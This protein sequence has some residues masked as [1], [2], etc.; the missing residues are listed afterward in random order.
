MCDI[1]AERLG[2]LLCEYQRDLFARM[3]KMNTVSAQ[4]P[5]R[6]YLFTHSNIVRALLNG[7]AADQQPTSRG[8]VDGH[9]SQWAAPLE[10]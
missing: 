10:Q 1:S 4:S 3:G 9:P 7:R 8:D 2:S 5:V 6:R